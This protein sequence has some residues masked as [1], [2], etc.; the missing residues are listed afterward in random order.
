[1]SGFVGSCTANRGVGL[2]ET[3]N[4]LRWRWSRFAESNPKEAPDAEGVTIAPGK[5]TTMRS[6]RLSGS[7]QAKDT[8]TKNETQTPWLD[9][10][11]G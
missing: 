7:I 3:D 1:M 5:E 4:L 8:E 2:E 10:R 6:G 9:E 11:G